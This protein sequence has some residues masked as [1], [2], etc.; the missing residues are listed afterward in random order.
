MLLNSGVVLDVYDD[1]NGE[2]LRSV[3]PAQDSLPSSVK[4][5]SVLNGTERDRLPDDVFALVLHQDGHTLRKFACIDEGNTVLSV[6]YFAKNA[7]KLPPTVR[8]QVAENL[9]VAC[10]W[11]GLKKEAGLVGTVMTGM[12]AKSTLDEMGARNKASASLGPGIHTPNEVTQAMKQAEVVGTAEMPVAGVVPSSPEPKK[13]PVQ[14]TASEMMNDGKLWKEQAGSISGYSLP[15]GDMPNRLPQMKVMKPVV[16]GN[17]VA[18][19]H[20]HG[21]KETDQGHK[22]A[23]FALGSRYPLDS[24]SQVKAAAAYFDEFGKRFS[25]E[26]R[27]EYCV[28]LVK[29]ASA[30][31]LQVSDAVGKYGSETF[32][33]VDE[34]K[35]AFAS[36]RDLLPNAH[37]G[38]LLNALE[39]QAGVIDPE[40]FC[41]ALEE[42]DKTAGIDHLYDEHVCDP[43][44]ST[45]GQ[46][47]EA[48]FAEVIGA[49]RVTASDLECLAHH[50]LHLVKKT[51][52]D[53][54]AKEFR[55]DP[56]GI[57]K[58]LPVDTKKLLM[59]MAQECRSE[60]G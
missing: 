57:Y 5:A 27:H 11:Y 53:D 3:F 6:V 31:G 13:A 43:Y 42:F 19:A 12:Q 7:H 16:D 51:F 26:D 44:Y 20:P 25:P 55:K 10:S 38:N 56:V 60:N 46:V 28:N 8:E 30:L 48:E 18:S 23:H 45:F 59:R 24:Y 39:K 50:G 32:A 52:D 17:G 35:V 22:V 33:P 9:K 21:G 29:R 37:L 58:S 36:R 47:K 4:T 15:E 41:S 54:M 14:K 40:L 2:V 1:L 49:D 34:I